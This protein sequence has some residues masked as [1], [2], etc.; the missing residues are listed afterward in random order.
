MYGKATVAEI[1][2]DYERYA[3]CLKA[4]KNVY[5]ANIDEPNSLINFIYLDTYEAQQLACR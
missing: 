1:R 4:R 5:L 2:A 3:E